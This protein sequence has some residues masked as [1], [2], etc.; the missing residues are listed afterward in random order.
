MNLTERNDLIQTLL[1]DLE[2]ELMG[3][4]KTEAEQYAEV[5]SY[6]DR[7]YSLGAAD[8]LEVYEAWYDKTF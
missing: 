3:T 2:H 4:K 8:L 6:R 5:A 1:H 7:L